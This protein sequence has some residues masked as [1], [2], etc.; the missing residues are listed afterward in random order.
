MLPALLTAVLAG[1]LFVQ[2]GLVRSDDPQQDSAVLSR[3][4]HGRSAAA[5]PVAMAAADAVIRERPI[6]APARASGGGSSGS[7]PLGGAQVSGAWAVG[8]QIN[9]VLRQSDGTTRTMRVGQTLNQWTL[10]SVTPSGA[11]FLRDG[12]LITVPFGATAPT[13]AAED[14]QKEEESQ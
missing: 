6:F 12:K 3:I 14:P 4:G 13:P 10:A 5:L 9:L 11:R 2:L 8:R 7:D 1:M